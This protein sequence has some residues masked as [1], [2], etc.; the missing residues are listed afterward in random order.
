MYF[1]CL[2]FF[3]CNYIAPNKTKTMFSIVK[4]IVLSVLKERAKGQ[5][6]NRWDEIEI[7]LK[8]IANFLVHFRDKIV[9]LFFVER[10]VCNAFQC[11]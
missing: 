4:P 11:F 3:F 10:L 1:V 9:R 5:M 7:S 8:N 2:F 6:N